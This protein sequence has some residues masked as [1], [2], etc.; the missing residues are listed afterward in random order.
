MDHVTHILMA[1]KLLKTCG[2]DV[3]ASIYS[4]L[5]ALDREPAH[6]HRVY[7]HVI[8]NFPRMLT[9]ATK[10]F[11]DY[12]PMS[13]PMDKKSYEFDRITADHDYYLQLAKDASVLLNDNSIL[14][15]KPELV[16]GG[17]SLLS[18]LY[19][20]TYNN[21]V[22]A[23]LPDAVE[24]SGQWDFWRNVDYMLFRTRFYTDRGVAIFRTGILKSSIWDSAKINPYN[25]VKAMIIR[26]GDLSQPVTSYQTVDS[27]AKEYLRFLGF[28]K[29]VSVDKELA[30]CLSLEKEIEKLI[31]QTLDKVN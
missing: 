28:T 12:W 1:Y 20:D 9:T 14:T 16:G 15:Q 26:L 30:F 3:G 22:Q 25:M 6:F 24:P 31:R 10:I 8:S 17:L 19:F 11:C 4:V 13:Y 7:A 21:P 27:K 5:P 23:F 2:C 29:Y 18:H